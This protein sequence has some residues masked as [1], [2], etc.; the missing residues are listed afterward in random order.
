[1]YKKIPEQ[2]SFGF[3]I[4]AKNRLQD[5]KPLPLHRFSLSA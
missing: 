2:A 4:I 1:M 3:K 5:K